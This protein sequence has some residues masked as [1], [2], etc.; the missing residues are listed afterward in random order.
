MNNNGEQRSRLNV[1]TVGAKMKSKR[2]IWNFMVTDVDAFLP[3][4]HCV[5]IYHLKD[6]LSGKKKG[7]YRLS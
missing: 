3:H 1:R 6:L 7:K 2:E 4:E 5:T